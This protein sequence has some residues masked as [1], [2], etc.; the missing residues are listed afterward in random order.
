MTLLGS[1]E[2]NINE[3]KIGESIP[4]LETTEVV[5]VYCNVVSIDYQLDSYV[6]YIFAPSKSF[7]HFL[8]IPTTNLKFLKTFNTKY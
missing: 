3:D 1:N 4:R 7:G 5:L 8:E 2:K 6:L